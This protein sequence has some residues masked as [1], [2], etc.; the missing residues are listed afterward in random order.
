MTFSA[1]AAKPEP[2]IAVMPYGGK[3]GKALAERPLEEME[4]PLG[5]PDR[6]LGKRVKDMAPDDHLIAYAKRAMHIQSHRS[7]PARLSMIVAEPK[8]MSADHHR[9]L[10][11]SARRFFRVFTY[12][13]SLLARLPNGLMLPFGTTWVPEW[14][15]L[16]ITKNKELSLIASAK[17]DHPGHKLRH[18]IV[19]HL[20]AQMPEADILG[21]GY[22]AFDNKSDGLAP[23][24]YSVV[25]E[26]VQEPNYFTE[27]LIDAILCETVP[28]YWGCPNIS[29]FFA[30][31][32]IIQCRDQ[33][34]LV[35]ALQHIGPKD[36]ARRLSALQ[37]LKPVAAMFGDLSRRAAM[38]LR[39]SL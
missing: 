10:R 17:N 18:R 24:R 2:A 6:L 16:D 25:I 7:C 1:P 22:K 27:K 15:Q 3:L 4:W 35:D 9:L 31:E 32:G 5:C 23:Y 12:D 20:Q 19:S 29:D 14:Q 26:N 8:I 13:P 36:Y 11:L 37:A 34:E 21:R 39:D 30:G 38:A 33:Q 28:I